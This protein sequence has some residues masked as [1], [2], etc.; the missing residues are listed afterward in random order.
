MLMERFCVNPTDI[1]IA[2][3]SY[4]PP[5]SYTIRKYCKHFIKVKQCKR[6]LVNFQIFL[7]YIFST[8]VFYLQTH[9]KNLI[10]AV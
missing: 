9:S 8:V 2:T 1:D 10:L 7:F 4:R 3:Y 5:T 6:G